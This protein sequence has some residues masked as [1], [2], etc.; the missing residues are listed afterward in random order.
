MTKKEKS[1][2]TLAEVLI[3]LGII[4]VVAALTMPALIQKQ[5]EKSRVVALKKFYSAISQAYNG[6]VNEYGT[7]DLWGINETNAVPLLKNLEKY[8]KFVKFCA[9]NEK[10]HNSDSILA[11]NNV[12]FP[13]SY[14]FNP[15]FTR[16]YAGILADGMIISAY[17]LDSNCKYV[18][19]TGKTLENICGEYIVDVNG[20]KK[21][22]QLGEDVF[23]FNI[24][25][26]GIT[27]VGTQFYTDPSYDFNSGCLNSTVG[28]GCA[29]W[30]ITNENMEYTRC[31]NLS[32]NKTTCK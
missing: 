27:P 31:K 5:E 3:T 15:G 20:N 7:P 8:M 12:K 32:W 16:R 6:A 13:N 2:F 28:W 11:R 24:T 25:Q 9:V 4:G 14:Y 18:L 26:Y 21:P 29:G 19:G 30:V 23:L 1:A 22:N 17:V 10:C